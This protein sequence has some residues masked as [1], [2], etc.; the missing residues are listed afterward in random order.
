MWERGEGRGPKGE[1]K[2]NDT[3]LGKTEEGEYW[4]KVDQEKAES[5]FGGSSYQ[6]SDHNILGDYP[7]RRQV[8]PYDEEEVLVYCIKRVKYCGRKGDRTL[9]P[10]RVFGSNTGSISNFQGKLKAFPPRGNRPT[11]P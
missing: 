11:N 3:S 9:F 10:R 2:L 6:V 5:A 4:R 8:I 7:S 1:V